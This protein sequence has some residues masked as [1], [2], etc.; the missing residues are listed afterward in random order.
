MKLIISKHTFKF[1]K[2]EFLQMLGL[3][4]YELSNDRIDRCIWN[5]DTGEILLQVKKEEKKN[6]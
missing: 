2:E 6:D 5:A 3:E 4:K 1:T